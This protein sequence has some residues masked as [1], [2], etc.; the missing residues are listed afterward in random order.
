MASTSSSSRSKIGPFRDGGNSAGKVDRFGFCKSTKTAKPT[1]LICIGGKT[2]GRLSKKTTE[3]AG[4]TVRGGAGMRMDKSNCNRPYGSEKS[5]AP[6][7]VGMKTEAKRMSRFTKAEKILSVKVWKP[8]G[9]SCPV[10]KLEN[11]NGLWV[12]YKD[13]GTE[14]WRAQYRDGKYVFEMMGF[15]QA[16]S[17]GS[18]E[19]N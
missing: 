15:G 12:R 9:Q 7:A 1:V 18:L 13:D 4:L 2:E 10:T 14:A 5:R 19:G 11:G 16:A 17:H 8:N 6:H 3:R